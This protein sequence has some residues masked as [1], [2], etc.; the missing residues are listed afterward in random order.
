MSDISKIIRDFKGI[1][2]GQVGPK[3]HPIKKPSDILHARLSLRPNSS[4]VKIH[5]RK[6]KA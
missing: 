6:E 3:G 5:S 1:G 4:P 2:K